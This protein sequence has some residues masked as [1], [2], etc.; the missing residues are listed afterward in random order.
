MLGKPRL[1]TMSLLVLVACS[2]RERIHV[3][4]ERAVHPGTMDHSG[5]DLTLAGAAAVAHEVTAPV[6][7]IHRPLRVTRRF[8]RHSVPRIRVSPI[9]SLNIEA[10]PALVAS[11]MQVRTL[12]FKGAPA[13]SSRTG[14]APLDPGQTVTSIP[15]TT[16]DS[17]APSG[18][19]FEAP[20]D[21]RPHG[22]VGGGHGGTCRGRGGSR[23]LH[24]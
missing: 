14:A 6:E 15:A 10:P 24:Q 1:F 21:T 3:T 22:F 17:G 23:R 16:V 20:K 5:R 13:L 2:G 8:L 9:R 12:E 11:P 7:L 18:P 4:A 19:S